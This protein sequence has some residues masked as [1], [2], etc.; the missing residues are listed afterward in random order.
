[1]STLINISL[2][3]FPLA[4]YWYVHRL[5][6]AGS[7][8]ISCLPGP[9][10]GH[11]LW[12][13]EL[14][15]HQT[16]YEGAYT[17]WM[18]LYGLTYKIKGALFHPDILVI[19]DQVALRDI[20]GKDTYSYVKSPIIRALIERVIGRGL[21]WAEGDVHKRQRHELA[22]FFTAKAIRNMFNTVST[23]TNIGIENLESHIINNASDP[24]QGL[25]VDIMESTESMT[26]DIT[27]RFVLD[28]DFESGKG[29]LAN[30][31][32]QT[33]KKQ[34]SVNLH[35]TAVLGQVIIRALPFIAHLPIPALKAQLAVKKVLRDV[36]QAVVSQNVNEG[37]DKD[38]LTAMVRLSNKGQIQGGQNELYDQ[39]STI[40]FT[41]QDTTAGTLTFGLHQL[42][43]HPRYQSRLRDEIVQLGRE[44]TYDDLMSG[45]PWLDAITMEIFRL[46]PVGAHMERVAA[47]DTILRF[48]DP[49][50]TSHGAKISEIAIKAGQTIIIPITAMN[51]LKSVW[52]DDAEELDPE[53]WFSPARLKHVDRKFGW[54]GMLT[55]SDGPRHCIGYRMAV[56][57][58]KTAL[59]AYIRKFEFHDTGAVIHARYVGTLQPYIANE[60]EKGTQM[61]LRVTL[62]NDLGDDKAY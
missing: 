5:I 57:I 25:T 4:A 42:A 21:A 50:Q 20:L 43:I 61:P 24:K 11:W 45:M 58:F 30:F 55:F 9:N 33:W 59:A 56:L 19:G 14:E 17:R 47:Q 18:H 51:H 29:P 1:M 41:S 36:S 16:P 27:G 53:R 48:G 31:I 7:N 62:V 44:P 10:G 15:A 35:W 34:C 46:R 52:G 23:C 40:A 22:P 49:V 26:L 8:T 3:L 60:E 2:F 38:L 37:Q 32:K 54:N 12:G 39:V 28:Y 6:R 13:H